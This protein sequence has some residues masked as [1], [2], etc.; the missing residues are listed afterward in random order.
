[1]KTETMKTT[2]SEGAVEVTRDSD[3]S[4]RLWVN[5]HHS[6]VY[7]T[8]SEAAHLG[9]LLDPAREAA[10]DEHTSDLARKAEAAAFEAED[11]DGIGGMDS[12]SVIALAAHARTLSREV[13]AL[14]AERDAAMALVAKLVEA[15]R[16]A[17]V[18]SE[19][20]DSATAAVRAAILGAHATALG[21]GP[22]QVGAHIIAEAEERGAR[23]AMEAVGLPTIGA[24]PTAWRR[25]KAAEV[26]RAARERT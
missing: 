1:M 26:C 12:G 25:V 22:V 23:W 20:A 8:A 4:L 15:V 21:T 9:R 24:S 17:C 16:K 18:A 3:G 11:P 13:G 6:A 10:P 19:P 14:R 5:A 7:L 2:M